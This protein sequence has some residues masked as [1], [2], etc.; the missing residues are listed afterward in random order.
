MS[1]FSARL[2]AIPGDLDSIRD[3]IASIRVWGSSDGRMLVDTVRVNLSRWYN[4]GLLWFN[5][6]VISDDES[7]VHRPGPGVSSLAMPGSL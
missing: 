6:F 5:L 2:L 4:N 7:S 1:S 3:S